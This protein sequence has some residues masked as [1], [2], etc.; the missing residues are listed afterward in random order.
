MPVG[1]ETFS[2]SLRMGA[3]IFHSLKKALKDA[4]HNTNVGDEGGFAPDLPS[5]DEALA[6]LA[7]AV[8]TA[9][10]QMGEDVVF[11][12][13]AGSSEFFESDR[14]V[15][16]GE[17][18]TLDAAGMVRLY[19]ELCGRYPIVSIED[20]M[21]EGDWDGIENTSACL[22]RSLDHRIW[23]SA[24]PPV[25]HG[26]SEEGRGAMA[27]SLDAAEVF[28]EA[29]RDTVK[30]YSLWYLIQGGLLTAAG[31]LNHLGIAAAS[32]DSIPAM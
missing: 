21:A 3:E 25:R 15:L 17:G 29:M 12:L 23:E 2:D 8:E 26:R 14:Y 13:D 1:A 19:E 30:R 24:R 16:A 20:G 9:G 18:R 5:T 31:V 22:F 27:L 4:G 6:F 32:A 7:R 11:A 28:R 10:F